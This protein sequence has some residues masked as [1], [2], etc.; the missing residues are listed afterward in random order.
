MYA[1]GRSGLGAELLVLVGLSSFYM[2]ALVAML[3]QYVS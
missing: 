2:A 3:A 1:I